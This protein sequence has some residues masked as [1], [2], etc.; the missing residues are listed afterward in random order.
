MKYCVTN[1][2]DPDFYIGDSYEAELPQEAAIAERLHVF[3]ECLKD[4]SMELMDQCIDEDGPIKDRL[5]VLGADGS[6]WVV[7]IELWPTFDLKRPE[8]ERVRWTCEVVSCVES[9]VRFRW[10]KYTANDLRVLD[11]AR[12]EPGESVHHICEPGTCRAC[13]ELD[14]AI[15]QKPA[16]EPRS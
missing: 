16:E 10:H 2:V 14:N 12:N 4:E 5:L 3:H 9:T 11:V 8:N 13:V 15:G 7:S 6:S 1:E